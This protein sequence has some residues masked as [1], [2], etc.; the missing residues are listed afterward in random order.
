MRKKSKAGKNLI[1]RFKTR[2]FEKNLPILPPTFG[3]SDE[4]DNTPLTTDDLNLFEEYGNATS[5][6]ASLNPIDL[7]K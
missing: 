6:L 5:F 2:R 7:S 4:H 3:E 1:K